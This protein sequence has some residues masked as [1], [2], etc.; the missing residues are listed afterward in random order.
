[1]TGPGGEPV[2]LVVDDEPYILSAIGRSLRRERL[3]VLTAGSG[4]E[5]LELLARQRVDAV[6]SD[7]KMPGMDGAEFLRRARSVAPGARRIL[8]TGWT[9]DVGPALQ[10]DLELAAVIPKPWDDRELRRAVRTALGI[11]GA[12]APA[13][14]PR[15]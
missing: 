7:Y 5:A 1:M 11:G 15:R 2:L 14:R 6:L 8:L 9:A 10:R 4:S 13:P 3:R 12:A